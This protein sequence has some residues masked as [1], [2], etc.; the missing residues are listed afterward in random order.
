[1]DDTRG[2]GVS[3]GSYKTRECLLLVA[4]GMALF[5]LGVG[6]GRSLSVRASSVPSVLLCLSP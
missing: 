6:A 3:D 1:M 5:L 4:L 2:D